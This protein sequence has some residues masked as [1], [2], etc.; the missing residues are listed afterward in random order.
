MLAISPRLRPIDRK[1]IDDPA[2]R[3]T[4]RG[5][6]YQR[7]DRHAADVNQGPF[8]VASDL[9]LV[10]GGGPT[11]VGNG[12]FKANVGRYFDGG[13]WNTGAVDLGDAGLNSLLQSQRYNPQL[14]ADIPVSIGRQYELQLLFF[15]PGG[16]VNVRPMTI[17]AEGDIYPGYSITSSGSV[18][19]WVHY[20]YTAKIQR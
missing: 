3:P 5:H 14:S 10:P 9:G 8:V 12:V 17:A 20:R 15:E 4:Q 16:V 2:H 19:T 6:V 7:R 18:T 11:T 13:D 1:R